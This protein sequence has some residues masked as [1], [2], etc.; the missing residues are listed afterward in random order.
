MNKQNNAWFQSLGVIGILPII[1]IFVLIL[2]LSVFMV[3]G[4][5]PSIPI[6]NQNMD[7]QSNPTIDPK[8]GK[9][10]ISLFIFGRLGVSKSPKPMQVLPLS[11]PTP[12]PNLEVLNQMENPTAICPNIIVPAYFY[13][14]DFWPELVGST[15]SPSTIGFI[16]NPQSGPGPSIDQSLE[17]QVQQARGNDMRI[18]AY[19]Y[20]SF[21]SRSILDIEHDVNSYKSM[22]GITNIL[23]DQMSTNDKDL[24]YYQTILTYVHTVSPSSN[25]IFDAGRYPDSSFLSLPASF[26]VFDGP[27]SLFKKTQ[28]PQYIQAYQ[29]NKFIIFVYATAK[30][31]VTNAMDLS[32]RDHAGTMYITDNT[33]SANPYSTMPSYWINELSLVSAGCTDENTGKL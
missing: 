18:Y 6:Q 33:D 4:F 5:I 22:Y 3:S 10:L 11:T 19:V 29:S 21:G 12:M 9:Q 20:T 7:N 28:P 16:F 31:D 1:A 27:Y 2:V 24:S 15:D 17:S 26:V 32:Q 25:V 14:P 23:F 8:L 30:N 13:P